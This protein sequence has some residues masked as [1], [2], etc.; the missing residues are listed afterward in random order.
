MVATESGKLFTSLSSRERVYRRLLQIKKEM[1]GPSRP[2]NASVAQRLRAIEDIE[3]ICGSPGRY[4]AEGAS[5]R[6]TT[7]N[8]CG[9]ELL[10]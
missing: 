6:L 1:D 7:H 5:T 8:P 9:F 4:G 10:K 3:G 2:I